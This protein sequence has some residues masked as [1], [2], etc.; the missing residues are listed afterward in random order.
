MGILN[1]SAI[2]AAPFMGANE[3]LQLSGG[4]V[5]LP[6][7]EFSKDEIS[8]LAALVTSDDDASVLGYAKDTYNGTNEPL[9]DAAAPELSAD[10]LHG[11]FGQNSGHG[12]L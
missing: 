4:P 5:P 11:H 1:A 2:F 7:R 6:A 10:N 9:G 3:L 8:H 12:R